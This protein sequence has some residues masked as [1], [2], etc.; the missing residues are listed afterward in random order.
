MKEKT[1]YLSLKARAPGSHVIIVGTHADLLPEKTKGK[2]ID[3]LRLKI[4]K[5]YNKK[6]YPIIKGNYVVSCTTAENMVTLRQA[7]YAAA[8]ELK[9]SENAGKGES[10][11]GRKVN[12]SKLCSTDFKLSKKVS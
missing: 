9:E 3:E 4:G 6:G 7:I 11:I 5:R 1:L 10:L 2:R 12:V 8:L